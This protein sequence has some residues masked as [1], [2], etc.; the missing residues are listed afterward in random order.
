M[1]VS[2]TVSGDGKDFRVRYNAAARG[3]IIAYWLDR[4]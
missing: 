3:L 1:S 2:D 4:Y